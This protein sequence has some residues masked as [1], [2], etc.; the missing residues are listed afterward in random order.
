MFCS[1]VFFVINVGAMLFWWLIRSH[2]ILVKFY[3]HLLFCALFLVPLFFF[4]VKFEISSFFS[5]F[6]LVLLVVAYV[7]SVCIVMYSN[8]IIQKC[9][10]LL[11]WITM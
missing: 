3:F 7:L 10:N 4:Y 2:Y 6:C 8:L 11:L 1:S 5:L 9:G